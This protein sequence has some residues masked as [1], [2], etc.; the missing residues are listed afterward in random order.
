MFR[1]KEKYHVYITHNTYR[2]MLLEAGRHPSNESI[3]QMPGLRINNNF[4]YDMVAD[5]GVNATYTPTMCEKDHI[6][7]DHLATRL[8][9]YYDFSNGQLT[10]SQVHRHPDGYLQ[11]SPGDYPA[12]IKLARQFGGVVNGLIFVDPEF[13]IKFWYID[14]NG[15]ETEAEYEINDEAVR[16]AMPHIDLNRLKETVERNEAVC[17]A[18]RRAE[19]RSAVEN[20][21]RGL[22]RSRLSGLFK[23]YLEEGSY[24]GDRTAAVVAETEPVKVESAKDMFMDNTVE[25]GASEEAIMDFEKMQ[26]ALKP[27]TVLIPKEFRKQRYEGELKGYY[28]PETKTYNI[29]QE[30]LSSARTDVEDLGMAVRKE[31]MER[32]TGDISAQ[33]GVTIVWNNDQA[34]ISI[35]G[36][37]E[38]EINIDYYSTQQ[39]VFSRNQGIVEKDRMAAKQA[40]ISGTGSGGFKVGLELVRAGIG[41]LLVADNDILAYHNICRHE[42]GIHDVGRYKVDC[43]KERAADINPNCKIYTFRDLIQHVDPAELEKIIW[44]DSIILCCADNRHCGYVCNKLADKYH[45]PMIDAGCGPRASTGEVFWYKPD[46]GMACYTCAYGEDKGVDYSNQAV[47]RRFYATERELEKLDFQPGMYLDIQLTAIFEAKLAIDLLMENEEGYEPKLLPYIN[48]CTVL[49]NYPVDQDVNPYMHLF[50]KE[51]ERRPFTWKSGQAQKNEY[52]SYC[53]AKKSSA[54]IGCNTVA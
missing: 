12:N 10:V 22:I 25:E 46:S 39:D 29:V 35:R 38:A 9:E 26:E 28:H 7:A 37:V 49:L 24:M 19:C 33:F 47:R 43:F 21:T 30:E 5:S 54:D 6:Y 27:Y 13:R 18:V 20:E 1:C 14:E 44:K 36:N 32:G 52:C 45:I 15:D 51:G 16:A 8:S 3:I 40:I 2:G 11:F 48:Q 23:G 41:S 50:G 4:Y 17:K 42:C 34:E 31:H 53:G